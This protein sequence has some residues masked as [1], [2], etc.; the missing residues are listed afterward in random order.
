MKKSK[1]ITTMMMIIIIII[2]EE[3][4]IGKIEDIKLDRTN[5]HKQTHRQVQ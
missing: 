4:Q 5:I 1:I 2:T 3:K